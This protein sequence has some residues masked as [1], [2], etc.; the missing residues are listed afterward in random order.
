MLH[1]ACAGLKRSPNQFL[2]EFQ[3][4]GRPP[5]Q[6]NALTAALNGVSGRGQMIQLAPPFTPTHTTNLVCSG[7][8]VL[9]PD[10]LFMAPH[11][12]TVS[13][14]IWGYLVQAAFCFVA[15]TGPSSHS[16]LR[17]SPLCLYTWFAHAHHSSAALHLLAPSLSAALRKDGT[18]QADFLTPWLK[19]TAGLPPNW[20]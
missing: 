1:H 13:C 8:Q 2:F 6:C 11:A 9:V 20:T 7:T 3:P 4:L 12:P 14:Q 5:R 16:Y 17:V 15:A 19:T 10:P 18:V